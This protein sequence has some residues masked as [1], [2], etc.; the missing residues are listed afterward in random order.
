MPKTKTQW[1]FSLARIVLASALLYVPASVAHAQKQPPKAA[2]N[3][4]NIPEEKLDAAAAAL[5]R[6]TSIK[7]SYD[8]RMAEAAT[9]SAKTA[10]AKEADKEM[11]KAI[12]D[13][14]LTLKEYASIMDVAQN[15][16]TV[17]EK[18]LRRIDPTE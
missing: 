14:G 7:D 6:A 2:G 12:T 17:R 15:D 9:E 10:L 3:S 1:R 13:Q 8:N 11:S 4:T 16:A 18:L 5:V